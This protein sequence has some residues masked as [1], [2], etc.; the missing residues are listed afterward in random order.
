MD[1]VEREPDDQAP[2]VEEGQAVPLPEPSDLVALAVEA[3]VAAVAVPLSGFDGTMATPVAPGF[4]STPPKPTTAERLAAWRDEFCGL[5]QDAGVGRGLRHADR[6]LRLPGGARRRPEH[7]AD[8]R[9]SGSPDRQQAA[10][11]ASATPRRGDIVMLYYPLNP[12]KSFVKRVI[13]E[14]G[15]TVRIVDGRVYVNDVPMHDDYVPRGVSQPRRLGPAGDSRGLLLRDGRPPEQQLRQPPLGHRA[16]EV[17]HRQGAG[18]LVA[19][20]RTARV[21]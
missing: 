16:E 15:D 10:S 11:T 19:G 9:G 6:H 12:D 20:A 13:A 1:H 21:F 4:T 5:G 7:G 17:H 2:L 14:E 18:A 3:P 8:A